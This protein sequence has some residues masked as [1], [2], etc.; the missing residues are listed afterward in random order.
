MGGDEGRGRGRWAGRSG[1]DLRRPDTG[2][3]ERPAE[4]AEL[5]D[6]SPLAPSRPSSLSRPLPLYLPILSRAAR[7][8]AGA[9]SPVPP[10]ATHAVYLY[11]EC[12]LD[13]YLSALLAGYPASLRCRGR[14]AGGPA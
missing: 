5:S 13:D 11:E 12:V 9:T 8:A 7:P 6:L 10:V 3:P 1:V 2:G 4:P 14:A